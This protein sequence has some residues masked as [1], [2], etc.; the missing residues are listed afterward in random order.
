MRQKI[1]VCLISLNSYP[2]FVKNSTGYFGGA[3]VQMSLIAKTLAKD[4]QFEVNLLVGDYGQ[5]KVVHKNKVTLIKSL[6]KKYFFWMHW[7]EL[8]NF[9]LTLKNINADVYIERTMNPKL[10][11]VAVFCKL[12][13]KKLIYM[14]AHDWDSMIDTG[15]YLKK[16]N[17]CVYVWGL[18]KAD[19]IVAQNEMQQKQLKDNFGLNSVLVK[20]VVKSRKKSRRKKKHILWVGRAD[21]WKRPEMMIK[22]AK[23]F[24][25]EKVKMIC[26]QGM[27]KD[28]YKIIKKMASKYPN[29]EFL[30][31]VPFE[32]IGKYYSQAKVLINT[33]VAEGF[34]NTF[35]QAG[36]ANTPVV[37][38]LVN[39]DNYLEKFEAGFKANNDFNKLVNKTKQL[40]N[41]SEL[42]LKMGENH[43]QYVKKNHSMENLAKLRREIIKLYSS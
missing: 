4:G 2:L 3:E 7:W 33:S 27:N 9:L 42:S 1:K 16:L 41:K 18:K 39:P 6:R 8:V 13:K 11:V 36:L 30:P 23:K 35:L 37:S 5:K 24:P 29:V 40:M 31:V 22:L 14:M 38:L 12:F 43:F 26:R 20:S 21:K 15:N 19:L 25:K 17:R 34:P 32:K 28:Y 10:G